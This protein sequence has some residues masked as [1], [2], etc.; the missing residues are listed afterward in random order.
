MVKVLGKFF[1][2]ELL[3]ELLLTSH[4]LFQ[5]LLP[6][7]FYLRE[8]LNLNIWSFELNLYM[9]FFYRNLIVTRALFDFYLLIILLIMWIFDSIWYGHVFTSLW[10]VHWRKWL[11]VTLIHFVLRFPPNLKRWKHLSRG[12][13]MTKFCVDVDVPLDRK[14][15]F[16]NLSHV[17][18]LIYKRGFRLRS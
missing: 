8:V 6:L 11:Y 1:K 13:E 10:G 3:K 12:V 15:V 5:A 9:I 17:F 16:L 14:F 7:I 2:I 4:Y 18:D